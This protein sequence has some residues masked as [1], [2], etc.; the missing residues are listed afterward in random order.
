MITVYITRGLPASGKSTWAKNLIDSEPNKYKRV[1]KDDL[2]EMIDNGRFSK[3]NEKFVLSIRDSFVLSA[4]SKGKHVIVDDTNLHSKHI[5]HISNLVKGLAKVEI[6]D[7]T[8]VPIEECIRRDIK[9]SKSVGE[10]VI[11]DMYNM[12]LRK[13]EDYNEDFNLP[14]AIIVDVDGTLAKMNDRSPFDWEK[15]I[16]DDVNE[17]IR[18]IVNSYDGYVIVMSGRD[19]ICFEDTLNW[20]DKNDI[21]F[22]QLLM[23]DAGN[24]EKDSVIKRRLFEKHVRGVYFIDYVLDDRNQVVDMWRDMGLT[25]LQVDYGDF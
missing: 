7:F 20:L 3:D 4:I 10:K 25:C 1:N 12:F 19:G 13:Q 24:N 11:R 21:K 8:H 17:P 14:H 6:V 2:R 23:R 5:E 16:D 18:Q 9:R 22:D 15:V